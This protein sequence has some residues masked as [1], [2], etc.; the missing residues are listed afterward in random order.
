MTGCTQETDTHEKKCRKKK[1]QVYFKK[2]KNQ[3]ALKSWIAGK[4]LSI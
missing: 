1:N 3:L 2:K 4:E